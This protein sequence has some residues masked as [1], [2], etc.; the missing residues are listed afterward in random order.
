MRRYAENTTVPAERSQAEL[1]RMLR[2][3]GAMKH[4]FLEDGGHVAVAFE[5]EHRRVR[6]E[7]RAPSESEIRTEADA[8][9][10]RGWR[11]WTPARRQEWVREQQEKTLRQRWRALVLVVKAKLE[12][13][14][15]GQSTV[16][17][18]FLADIVLPNGKR[19]EEWLSPQ[20]ARAYEGGKMP[21]L[22]G[23]GS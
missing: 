3:H 22:L 5:L 19:V 18:E 15:D 2:A 14:A 20:L 1:S 17:R 7:I 21:P 12:L 6:L 8:D 10:P 11:S 23:S 4:G 13:I 9:P 16:E